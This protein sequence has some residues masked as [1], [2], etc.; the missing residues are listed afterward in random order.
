MSAEPEP[1][2]AAFVARARRQAA[3]AAE[4]T[5][6]RDRAIRDA[7]R[8]GASLRVLGKATGLS[9][10]GVRRVVGRGPTVGH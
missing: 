1:L 7:H 6:A 3:K 10:S 9:P 5:E 4:A 8:L 2:V